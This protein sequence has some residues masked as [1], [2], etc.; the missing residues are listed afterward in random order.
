MRAS[1]Q[2]W[3][4]EAI[5]QQLAAQLSWFHNCVLL[6]KVKAPSERTWYAEQA[7]QHGWSRNVLVMQIESYR[8]QGKALTNFQATLPSPLSDLAQPSLAASI[9]DM[10]CLKGALPTVEELE[11]ELG[12]PELPGT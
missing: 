10:L 12:E 7:I 3:P 8:R 11:A 9:D 2:A 1:A 4:D 5:V 6:D